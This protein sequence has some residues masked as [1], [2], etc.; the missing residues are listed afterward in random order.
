MSLTGDKVF[1]SEVEIQG[2]APRPHLVGAP[3]RRTFSR[4]GI[5]G[6]HR[7]RH[8]PDLEEESAL[9]QS[10]AELQRTREE[11][12]QLA[13]SL[14]NAQDA[15]RRR[16]SRELHD[17]LSQ[18]FAKL[19]FDIEMVEQQIPANL[20]AVKRR[21]QT[22]AAEAA[23]LSEDLRRLAHELH[24]AIL[25]ILG[26][27]AALRNLIREFARASAIQVRFLSL[28]VPRDL[29]IARAG[30]IFR[31]TQEALRNVRKHSRAT[32]L[33]IALTGTPA[34]LDLSIR[35]NGIGFDLET[36]RTKGGLGL[37]GMQERVRLVDGEF[38]METRPG[39]GVRIEISVPFSCQ[40]KE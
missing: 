4:H 13:A 40:G 21:L 30:S 23:G 39:H 5:S 17:D 27:S 9:R 7:L 35:D 2:V 11:L 37:I 36:A 34:G 15:E 10:H 19:Q 25:D 31:I 12:R 32:S 1:P 20:G 24:P 6:V 14:M 22:V 33:E 26:L 3:S 16:V 18:K 38:L 29:S 8:T 28:D